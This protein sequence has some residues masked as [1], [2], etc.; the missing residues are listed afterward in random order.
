MP[1]V[2]LV[3]ASAWEH[4]DV[5]VPDVLVPAGLVVLADRRALTAVELFQRER[6]GASG[7]EDGSAK[8]SERS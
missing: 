4:V 1:F 2:E 6:H 5:Q 8:L 7:G 3:A